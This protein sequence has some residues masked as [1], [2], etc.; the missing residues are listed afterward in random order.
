MWNNPLKFTFDASP[1]SRSSGLSRGVGGTSSTLA[2][3]LRD[4]NWPS[5]TELGNSERRGVRAVTTFFAD[6]RTVS[7]SFHSLVFAM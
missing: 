4:F 7:L 1:F 3:L 2:R 5:L 6:F